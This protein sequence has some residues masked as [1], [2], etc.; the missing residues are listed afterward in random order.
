MKPAFPLSRKLFVSH[1]LATF[2]VA[3]AIGL[4]LYLNAKESLMEQLRAR[5]QSSAAL[6]SREMDASELAGIRSAEDVDSPEYR[7]AVEKLRA[8]RRTNKD[9]A[10][11][12]V[13]RL[14]GNKVYFV[15]DTDETQ[16]QALPGQ[17]YA[18]V[19]PRL[20]E[21][22]S[23]QAADDRV[24]VDNWGAF[25]SGYAPVRGGV[26]EYLVG[27]DMR[28]DE[29]SRKLASLRRAAGGAIALALALSWALGFLMSRH[30]R[31]PIQ[32]IVEQCEAISR[33]ELDKRI[34]IQRLDEMDTLVSAINDLTRDLRRIRE[35]KA[36][37]TASVARDETVGGAH[38]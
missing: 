28:V 7:S 8:L 3:S 18:H 2:V 38:R 30:F 4:F 5:L 13:M 17:P 21:G 35:E 34:E 20:L 12:Y 25:L 31:R 11:L 15:V 37:P 14:A 23:R 36:S 32:A 10:F 26:G 24:T 27:I 6:I 19:N 29:V 1:F 9:I 16:A 33:G 22:F